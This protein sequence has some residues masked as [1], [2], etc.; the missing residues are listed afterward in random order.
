MTHIQWDFIWGPASGEGYYPQVNKGGRWEV[1]RQTGVVS[2]VMQVLNQPVVV[3]RE[4][5]QKGKLLIYR[6]IYVPTL[7]YVHNVWVMTEKNEAVGTSGQNEFC[8]L[9]GRAE[10]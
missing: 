2:V 9:G 5:S 3:K 4:L 8:L 1:N 10:C 6:S 7:I